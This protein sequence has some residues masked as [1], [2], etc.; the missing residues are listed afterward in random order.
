MATV[1]L[2]VSLQFELGFMRMLISVPVSISWDGWT[3]GGSNRL[4]AH[5]HLWWLMLAVS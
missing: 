4:N 2:L 1:I 3:A 5:S